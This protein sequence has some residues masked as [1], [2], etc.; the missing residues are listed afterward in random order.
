LRQRYGYRDALDMVTPVTVD[1]IS[2]VGSPT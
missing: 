2:G 1:G